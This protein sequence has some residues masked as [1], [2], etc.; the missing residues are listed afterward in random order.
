MEV[1]KKETYPNTEPE[2]ERCADTEE[3][4]ERG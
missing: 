4:C 3:G 1:A 2:I